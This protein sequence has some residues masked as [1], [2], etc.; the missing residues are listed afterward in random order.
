MAI[1]VKGIAS[2][3]PGNIK[4]D[5]HK[6]PIGQ[7]ELMEGVKDASSI[8]LV[9]EFTGLVGLLEMWIQYFQVSG[10]RPDFVH[11]CTAVS[12]PSNYTFLDSGQ[13]TGLLV[14][15]LG[16]AEYE[17][18]LESPGRGLKGMTAQ[19][20]A[21]L[22]IIVLIVVGNIAEQVRKRT[23]GRTPGGAT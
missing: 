23:A 5:A 21:H 8:D 15:M 20:A 4:E 22:L 1:L 7:I 9:C 12:G 11:G 13:I 16:A 18:I 14:G 2:D 19:T 17:Q 3:I 6:T 10:V